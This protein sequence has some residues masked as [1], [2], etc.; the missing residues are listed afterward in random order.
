MNIHHIKIQK[1]LHEMLLESY[2]ADL[3]QEKEL[4]PLH[5]SEFTTDIQMP[6]LAS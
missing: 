6:Q 1:S 5:V 2:Y 3:K 4:S